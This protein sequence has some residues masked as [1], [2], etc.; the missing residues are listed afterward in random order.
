MSSSLKSIT[1]DILKMKPWTYPSK[2]TLRTLLVLAGIARLLAALFSP[3]YDH[4]DEL[5]Q[6]L[7]PAYGAL[8]P[9]F[10]NQAWEWKEG[11]RSWFL[12]GIYAAIMGALELVGL[13]TPGQISLGVRLVTGV[14]SLITVK[15]TYELADRFGGKRAAFLAGLLS[16]FWWLPIY[17]GVRTQAEPLCMNVALLAQVWFFN[18]LDQAGISCGQFAHT[19]KSESEKTSPAI[20]A[21]GAGVLSGLAFCIRFQSALFGAAL[22]A[23]FLFHKQW[24]L[25]LIFSL[26]VLGV[27]FMQGILDLVTWGTFFHSPIEYFKFN[28]IKNGAAEQFGR[29]PFHRYI[30][31]FSQFSTP[32]IFCLFVYFAVQGFKKTRVL[33]VSIALF[34]IVHQ[35]IAHR[36]ARFMIPLVPFFFI[37]IAIGWLEYL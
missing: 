37:P 15:C 21:L 28:I 16:A 11:V 31:A 32:P 25:L 7:E 9:K 8:H 33:W 19:A 35:F 2:N 20:W 36:E 26:G 27:L 5:Y 6:V 23:I 3:G 34:F 10:W 13:R 24:R 18:A 1:S 4:P 17:Y 29:Q 12:P 30:V 14:F 22:G